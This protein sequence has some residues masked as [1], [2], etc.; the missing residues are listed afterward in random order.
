MKSEKNSI[1]F[2]PILRSFDCR[3]WSFLNAKQWRI[4][5]TT[6]KYW[7]MPLLRLVHEGLGGLVE[8]NEMESLL[9]GTDSGYIL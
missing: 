2:V 9:F 7:W 4:L 5:N 1:N 3:F 6:K 8:E